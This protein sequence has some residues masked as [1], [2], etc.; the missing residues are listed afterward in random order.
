MQH[1]RYV[2]ATRA[3]LDAWEAGS[4]HGVTSVLSLSEVLVRP[5]RDGDRTAT[6]EY[7]RLLTAFPNLRLL[8]VN[9]GIAEAAARLRAAHALAL[10]DAVQVATALAAGATG[11][12]SN[13]PDFKRVPGIEVLPLDEAV[14]AR[15]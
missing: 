13:D 5:F 15:R 9:R 6:E 2:R 12:V 14:S 7:R 1:P 4:H 3:I 11:F 10:P 8:D